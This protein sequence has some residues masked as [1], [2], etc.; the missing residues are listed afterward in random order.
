MNWFSKIPTIQKNPFK[1]TIVRLSFKVD[2]KKEKLLKFWCICEM[3]NMK[4]HI[5]DTV[6]LYCCCS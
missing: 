4:I 2:Q 5:Y 3:S 1:L 6:D